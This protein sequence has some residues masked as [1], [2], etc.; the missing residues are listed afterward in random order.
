MAEP[1]ANEKKNFYFLLT[2]NLNTPPEDKEKFWTNVFNEIKYIRNLDEMS[3]LDFKIFI[4]SNDGHDL[5]NKFHLKVT[6]ELN[7]PPEDLEKFWIV[8][9]NEIIRLRNLD[10]ESNLDIK[11][12]MGTN[13][14]SWFM[15]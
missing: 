15:P 8:V 9:A 5:R 1:A 7:T 2:A 3:K 13:E 12:Q 11:A 14:S 4:E 6:V 10:V